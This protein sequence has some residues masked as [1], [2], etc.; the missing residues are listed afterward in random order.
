MPTTPRKQ[1]GASQTNQIAIRSRT[2]KAFSKDIVRY[3]EDLARRNEDVPLQ[4]GHQ[5]MTPDLRVIRIPDV[6]EH[7]KDMDLLVRDRES[8]ML[9]LRQIIYEYL[10]PDYESLMTLPDG[11]S[12]RRILGK[13]LEGPLTVECYC[14]Q[15][16]QIVQDADRTQMPRQAS[17]RR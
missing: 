6:F 11:R 4:W 3:R 14:K 2:P 8:G 10:H 16:L 7:L 15:C 1:A 12:L 9:K 5:L 17:A 13:N